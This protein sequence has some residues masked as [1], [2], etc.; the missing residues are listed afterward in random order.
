MNEGWEW[1]LFG[2][3]AIGVMVLGIIWVL[4]AWWRDRQRWKNIPKYYGRPYDAS[5]EKY[6]PN[7]DLRR[8]R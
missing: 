6:R 7:V 4:V 2:Y 8:V 3:V 1:V 5:D